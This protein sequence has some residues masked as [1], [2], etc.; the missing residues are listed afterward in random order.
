MIIDESRTAVKW[1][2]GRQ[3]RTVKAIVGHHWGVDGQRHDNVVDFFC[4]PAKQPAD[5]NDGTSA[6]F[7][8]SDGRWHCIVS[9]NDTAWHAGSWATNLE[10]I[11][12]EMRPEATPGDYAAAA[13][14][15][16]WLRTLYGDVPLRAHREFTSTLCPGRWDLNRLDILA[17]GGGV[18]MSPVPTGTPITQEFGSHPGGFNP[19]GGHT[20]RDYGA[21]TGTYAVSRAPGT[22][23]W[24]DWCHKLPGG[25]NGWA[26]RWFFDLAFG[27]I[28]VVIQHDDGLITTYSHMWSTHLNPGDRVGYGEIVGETGNTGAA[29]S[30][31]HLHFEAMPANP[32]YASPTYGRIHPGP[33]ITEP[34]TSITT[35]TGTVPVVVPQ[36]TGAGEGA[37]TKKDWLS[38]ATK[39]EL[40]AVIREEVKNAD[41]GGGDKLGD[42]LTWHISKIRTGLDNVPAAVMNYEVPL[43]GLGKERGTVSNEASQV[44]WNYD[45][46]EKVRR[47]VVAQGK[48]L[49]AIGELVV[50]IAAALNIPTDTES[51][52][53]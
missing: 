20:G 9:P 22:V 42:Y 5:P 17:R 8:V 23:L 36:G 53:A 38:M 29:T 44:A 50:K 7:V 34:Y 32:N 21:W 41:L 47:Q 18:G 49:E 40:R 48:E 35:I 24:A 37:T 16:R 39:D 14:L 30:G 51:E 12:I 2:P 43:Q 33:Y 15:I 26:Q 45:R 27:G 28:I 13:S 46:V 6:H 31:D 10:T 11:G 19:S 4:N 25:A 52:A 1:T 3:G